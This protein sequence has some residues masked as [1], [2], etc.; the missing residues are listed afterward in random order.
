MTSNEMEHAKEAGKDVEETVNINLNDALLEREAKG[1]P[2]SHSGDQEAQNLVKNGEL[3]AED[4]DGVTKDAMDKTVV[5]VEEQIPGGNV[6]DI[7]G[8][9]SPEAFNDNKAG[10]ATSDSEVQENATSG[11]NI[12]AKAKAN[13]NADGI[14]GDLLNVKFDSVDSADNGANEINNNADVKNEDSHIQLLNEKSLETKAEGYEK[15]DDHK[16]VEA[17]KDVVTKMDLSPSQTTKEM[18]KPS[19]DEEHGATMSTPNKSF[20][21]EPT[22]SEGYESGTEEEQA[23]F[24]KEVETFYKENN[25]EFK[26]PKFYKEELNLLKLWRAV[27]KL[28]GYEQV[29]SCKLWRQV[30]ESFRP[31]KTC[32][33]VSWTFRIF[34]EKA[35]L[36]YE[37]H[38]M[39]C[40]ELPFSDASLTEPIRV[41]NQAVGSQAAGS[42]RAIRDAAARA[43]QGWHSQRLLGNGQVCDPIIKDKNSNSTPKSDKQLKS[44]GLLKRKKPS[45]VERAVHVPHTMVIDIGP[46]A[47][48]V[49]INV[50]RTNDCFEIYAL[51]PGL[52]REE[53]HVQ[54]DPAGRLIISGQPEQ[55]DN[56]WGVTPF[57]KVVSLPSRI[58]PHQTS[59]VVTLHGQLFVRVPFEQSD[60]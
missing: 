40:G 9:K 58:D 7:V 46:P 48:W 45:T 24:M 17:V 11:G 60:I 39:H 28:G 21:V 12:Q 5:Q 31:P 18:A 3:R 29:T 47:D 8:A 37:R 51:V 13:A 23:A 19:L 4:K 32:T 44:N 57:K 25:F 43:M 56:P 20:L 35:L 54:S 33:T 27:V 10:N 2:L 1:P 38:K 16:N 42:G 41:E 53:V 52:L 55:L 6:A 14:N 34:Y 30:G 49:K 15:V 59:A 50:Q 36:E 26:A 22:S